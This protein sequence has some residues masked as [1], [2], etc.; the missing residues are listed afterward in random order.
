V[1][2]GALDGAMLVAMAQQ[3]YTY[4]LNRYL[5]IPVVQPQEYE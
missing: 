4:V 5:R 2:G 1:F 3:V